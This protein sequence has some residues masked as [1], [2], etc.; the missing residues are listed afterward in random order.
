MVF[1]SIKTYLLNIFNVDAEKK[2]HLKQFHTHYLI[3]FN[4]SMIRRF[5]NDLKYNGYSIIYVGI[6]KKMQCWS[7]KKG[8]WSLAPFN[9]LLIRCQ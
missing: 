6:K 5:I 3:W 7:K 4:A 8:N 1:D 2:N 9:I